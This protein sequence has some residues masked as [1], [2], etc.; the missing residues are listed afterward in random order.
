MANL[1]IGDGKRIYYESYKGLPLTVVL[2]H[3]WGMSG[4]V[5]DRTLVALRG[6]GYGVVT[7]DHR[8]C[9]RSDKD[10]DTVR[11][12]LSLAAGRLVELLP[13]KRRNYWAQSAPDWC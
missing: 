4:R 3:G 13:W 1:T 11:I 5:W 8:S 12:E 9:G 10:F 2:I 6:E 7:F